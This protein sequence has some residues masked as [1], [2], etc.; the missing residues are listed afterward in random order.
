[1][2]RMD[3]IVLRAIRKWPSVPAV[4]GWLELDRRGNWSIKGERIANAAV[5]DFITRNYACDA[6][7]RWFFQNGPQ[8]VFVTLAYVPYVYRTLP[9]PQGDIGLFAHT[10]LPAHAHSGAWLD[11]TGALLVETELGVGLVHDLDLAG[12]ST[13]LTGPE[14]QDLRDDEIERLLTRAPGQLAVSHLTICGRT[15]SLS[16]I[17]SAEV[18]ARFNFV[19]NPRPAP[20]E[21][22]C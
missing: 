12:L 7:G 21:P 11:E 16:P 4:Y 3:E 8:R 20:D 15:L 19:P 22:D 9:S 17:A 10:G 18:P 13:A 14:G 6:L 5:I 1:M 2:Q